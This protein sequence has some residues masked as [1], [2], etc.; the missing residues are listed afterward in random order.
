MDRYDRLVQ[1]GLLLPS[2]PGQIRAGD[3]QAASRDDRLGRSRLGGVP[4]QTGG[5]GGGVR[6]QDDPCGQGD[7]ARG[8][9]CPHLYDGLARLGR[10]RLLRI[11]SRE[12]IFGRRF[13]RRSRQAVVRLQISE[14]LEREQADRVHDAALPQFALPYDDEVAGDAG[15]AGVLGDGQS[16]ELPVHRWTRMRSFAPMSAFTSISNR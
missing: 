16:G 14:R 15:G 5:M 6:R 9:F 13:S 1:L 8:F 7:Q 12:R 3:G 2:L 10:R 11:L 4:A